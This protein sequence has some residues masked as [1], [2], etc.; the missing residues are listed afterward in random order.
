[1]SAA[2]LFLFSSPTTKDLRIFVSDARLHHLQHWLQLLIKLL[3]V[4]AR[5]A[6]TRLL[7]NRPFWACCLMIWC[8]RK[9]L[10]TNQM[11]ST[12]DSHPQHSV[13]ELRCPWRGG[14]RVGG[15]R[16]ITEKFIL[17]FSLS[18]F[19]RSTRG[20][21]CKRLNTERNTS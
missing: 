4:R 15:R 14:G 9:L 16:E 12:E 8:T 2:K 3:A 21:R 13:S 18:Y 19:I 11:H 6:E 1:M 20:Q 10:L 5:K 7:L 17:S